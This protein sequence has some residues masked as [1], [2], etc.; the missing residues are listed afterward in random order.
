[1]DPVKIQAV[2]EHILEHIT[3]LSDPN[4]TNLLTVLGQQPLA[5]AMMPE[6]GQGYAPAEAK[7]AKMEPTD[8]G[9]KDPDLPNN[10]QTGQKWDP[11]TGGGV[12]PGEPQ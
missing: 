3:I 10:P 7:G 2:Q 9:E 12:I 4:F 8:T 11:S 5:M 6:P 1:M